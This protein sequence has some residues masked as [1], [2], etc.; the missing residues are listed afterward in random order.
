MYNVSNGMGT[1]KSVFQLALH[2]LKVWSNA[3]L[4]S[5]I[6][7]I[8]TPVADWGGGGGLGPHLGAAFSC[9]LFDSS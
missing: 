7:F 6:K 9:F 2:M 1:K 4:P 5:S 3:G 8:S